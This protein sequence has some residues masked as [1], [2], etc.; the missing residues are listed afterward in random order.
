MWPSEMG[1]EEDR[2]VFRN[3]QAFQLGNGWITLPFINIRYSMLGETA[4]E[5]RI[6]SSFSVKLSLKCQLDL[7]G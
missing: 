7:S 4:F 6:M 3:F 1:A 5:E 2:G